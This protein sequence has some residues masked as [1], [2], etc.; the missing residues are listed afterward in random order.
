MPPFK[1]LKFP[2]EPPKPVTRKE[3]T[4]ASNEEPLA[5][6]VETKVESP[7]EEASEL[8]DQ[9]QVIYREGESCGDCEY[10]KSDGEDCA[11]VQGPI[12]SNGWCVIFRSKGGVEESMESPE[13]AVESVLGGL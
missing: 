5:T 12:S 7:Q 10:F 3:V 13:D 8:L 11:K 4:V 2:M 6:M 1:A 9:S